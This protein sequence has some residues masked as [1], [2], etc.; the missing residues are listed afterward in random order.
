M[1]MGMIDVEVVEVY[2]VEVESE[3]YDLW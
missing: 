2:I 3:Q 1:I